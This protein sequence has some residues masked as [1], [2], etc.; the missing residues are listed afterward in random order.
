[1]RSTAAADPAEELRTKSASSPDSAP[2]PIRHATV[3][4]YPRACALAC[5]AR[6]P[7]PHGDADGDDGDDD[8]VPWDGMGG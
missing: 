8:E 6:V 2:H 4:P 5:Q 7:A 3:G 1:M